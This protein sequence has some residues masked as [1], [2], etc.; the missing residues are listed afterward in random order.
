MRQRSFLCFVVIGWLAACG[1]GVQ[2]PSR[3]TG[4]VSAVVAPKGPRALRDVTFERTPARL[5]R[6]RYLVE[7]VLQCFMCHSDRDWSKPGAPPMAGREGAGHVFE[8]APWLVAPNITPDRETG[9]GTW[10][11]DMFAR[12]IREGFGHD[13]RVLHPQMWYD[14]FRHL[15]DEDLASVIVYLRSLPPVRHALPATKLPAGHPPLM[16]PVPLTGP[17]APSDQ[18][19][20]IARGR[21]L[22][23]IADCMGCHTAF[24]APLVPGLFAGGNP[25]MSPGRPVRFSANLTRAPSGIGSCYTPELFR[26]VLRTGHLKGR[27]IDPAMPWIVFGRMTDR[28]LDDVFAYLQS[29][30]PVDHLVS[31]TDPPTMCPVCGQKHGL[32]DRNKP[33]IRATVDVDTTHFAEYAGDYLYDDGLLMSIFAERNRVLLQYQH[34]GPKIPLTAISQTEFTAQEIPDV[35]TF[36]RDRAGRV[37]GMLT[38][39]DDLGVRIR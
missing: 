35:I 16:D 32:G 17:V 20:A 10:T 5:A 8:N 39:V 18:S 13:G 26:D 28:D 37:T 1:R 9:A 23:R 36:V 7:G 19:T 12:A 3:A 22:V 38:N 2:S 6:G 24:E 4:P 33:K 27:A 29:R 15:S 25:I 31:N 14:A 34:V 11:D 30:R 21:Y